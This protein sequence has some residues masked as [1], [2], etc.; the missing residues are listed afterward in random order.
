MG[1]HF[2]YEKYRENKFSFDSRATSEQNVK[3]DLPFLLRQGE[4]FTPFCA[5]VNYEKLMKFDCV[6]TK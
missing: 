4:K 1:F 3:I 2:R 6:L 5:N